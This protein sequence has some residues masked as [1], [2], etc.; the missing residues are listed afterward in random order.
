MVCLTDLRANR[1][2]VAGF[3]LT[4]QEWDPAQRLIRDAHLDGYDQIAVDKRG[5]FLSKEPVLGSAIV[6][7]AEQAIELATRWW[8][9][10]RPL[11]PQP[12]C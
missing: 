4:V 11:S 8:L 1:D 3:L 5:V 10:F 12:S 7:T 9:M 6:D 2:G